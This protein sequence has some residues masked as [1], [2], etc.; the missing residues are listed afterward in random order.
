MAM[1][2]TMRL[3]IDRKRG[4]GYISPAMSKG[5]KQRNIL[6]VEL[7]TELRQQ[8]QDFVL[9]KVGGE[10]RQMALMTRQAIREYIKNHASEEDRTAEIAR[11]L[12]SQ[13]VKTNG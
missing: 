10:R 1:E 4:R 5:K 2:D 3:R 7:S 9:R 11:Q 8:W 6:R 13:A 12:L